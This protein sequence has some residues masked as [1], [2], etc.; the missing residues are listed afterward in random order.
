VCVVD[1]LPGVID[2]FVLLVMGTTV[3]IFTPQI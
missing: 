2:N 3:V 1:L